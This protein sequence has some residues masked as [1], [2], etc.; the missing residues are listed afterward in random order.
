[1]ICVSD[2][3]NLSDGEKDGFAVFYLKDSKLC[4]ISLTQEQAEILDVVI[5]MPFKEKGV[6]ISTPDPEI[7]KKY[8]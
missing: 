6:A 3:V 4:S 8:L 7:M 2:F 5:A 1:M